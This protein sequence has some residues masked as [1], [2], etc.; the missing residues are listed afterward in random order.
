[1]TQV[2]YHGNCCDGFGA[3]WAASHALGRGEDVTYVSCAYGQPIPPYEK[4]EDI[5][6]LDFSFPRD[7]LIRLSK[8]AGKLVVLDHHKTAE[9]D[10]RG[11]SFCTFD[12]ERSG[13]GLTWDH[14]HPNKPRPL[15]INLIEDRDLWKFKYKE[16]NAFQT[17]LSAH[18]F[19]FRVWDDIYLECVVQKEK[20]IAAGNHMLQFR[21]SQVEK[22]CKHSWVTEIK[23]H[24]AATVCATAFWSE[25]GTELLKKHIDAEFSASFGIQSDGKVLWSLRSR[26]AFD[27]SEIAKSFGGGGHKN[28]AGMRTNTIE[29]VFTKWGQK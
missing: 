18:P 14:F 11:L 5:Y 10:L 7:V 24:K 2:W 26:S 8:N 9:E 17:F 29:E 23:G 3:A 12:M 21:D 15:M 6:I 1:M 28:A 27:V 16:T 13:A 22:M 20:I 4:G 25:V 19:D